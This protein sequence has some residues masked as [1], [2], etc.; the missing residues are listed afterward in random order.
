[1][2]C[3]GGLPV[4]RRH[5]PGA[6]K[7]WPRASG[8]GACHLVGEVVGE[9]SAL[10]FPVVLRCRIGFGSQDRARRLVEGGQEVWTVHVVAGVGGQFHGRRGGRVVHVGRDG[11]QV[12]SPAIGAERGEQAG[13]HGVEPPQP[14]HSAGGIT[15][16]CCVDTRVVDAESVG[17]VVPVGFTEH[18]PCDGAV[19]VVEGQDQAGQFC[20][21]VGRA[22]P[23]AAIK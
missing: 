8:V 6:G 18:D 7:F 3:G 22:G 17:M 19:S 20:D 14:Y 4:G 16:V 11:D 9:L 10:R 1:M 5:G 2:D 12:D 21:W 23:P 13:G 15:A